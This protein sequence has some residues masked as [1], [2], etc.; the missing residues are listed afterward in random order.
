MF[1]CTGPMQRD[2]QLNN[3]FGSYG[4]VTHVRWDLRTYTQERGDIV[5]Y[6]GTQVANMV[7]QHGFK[8]C[9]R[10]CVQSHVYESLTSLTYQK[11]VI[12]LLLIN[13]YNFSVPFLQKEGF[14]LYPFLLTHLHCQFVFTS[15]LLPSANKLYDLFQFGINYEITN[16]I[17]CRQDSLD[18]R[19]NTGKAATY[20]EQHE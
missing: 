17:N 13:G 12:Y 9:L 16:I 14:Y 15:F 18:W 3:W 8:F 7:L 10:N 2:L 19:S 6:G 11:A 5:N 20:I 1:Q 4:H